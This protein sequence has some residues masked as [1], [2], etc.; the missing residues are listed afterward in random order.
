MISSILVTLSGI[1]YILVAVYYY[2]NYM[3][4]IFPTDLDSLKWCVCFGCWGIA[5]IILGT[6]LK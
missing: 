2:L 1:C 6:L 4:F 5:N 3:G